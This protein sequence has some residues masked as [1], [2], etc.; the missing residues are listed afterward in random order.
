MTERALQENRPLPLTD[1][2]Q[3]ELFNLVREIPGEGNWKAMPIPNNWPAEKVNRYWE[4]RSRDDMYDESY[5]P[6]NHRDREDFMELQQGL[7]QIEQDLDSQ[8][9]E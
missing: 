7:R 2:E 8:A 4:L 3:G 9:G 6:I 1:R 5:G